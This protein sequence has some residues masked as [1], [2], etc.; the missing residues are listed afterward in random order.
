MGAAI[1][2]RLRT[3]KPGL[4]TNDL[5]AE[6]E[7][8]GRLLFIGLW[9]IADREGRLEDRPRRIKA[10]VLPY[11]NADIDALLAALVAH[12]FI[13]RYA[14]HGDRFIAV[15]NFTK[16]QNPHVKEAP[17]TIPAPDMHDAS[18]V[19][20]L[21]AHP[22]SRAVVESMYGLLES[23]DGELMGES[24]SSPPT[25]TAAHADGRKGP[26][27]TT[28]KRSRPKQETKPAKTAGTSK[29]NP[30]S[31]L[32]D[33]LTEALGVTPQTGPER[34]RRGKVVHDLKE[35]G[36]TPEDVRL[37]AARYVLKYGANRLTDTA[38]VAHWSECDPTLPIPLPKAANDSYRPQEPPMYRAHV[39]ELT[40]E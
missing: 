11:D 36:A 23:M 4:F 25:A 12:G 8:L 15:C 6:I 17:S 29:P 34:S 28:Q 26:A 7:P 5:L 22:T 19:P 13:V 30:T 1:M 18:T 10:E 40:W 3:V 35:V 2:A 32:W 33:A 31:P 21:E 16:H 37:R 27:G 14:A 20:A 38:L 39:P 24:E 9:C